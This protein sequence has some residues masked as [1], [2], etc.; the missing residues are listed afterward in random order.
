MFL[1]FLLS[2][3]TDKNT[4]TGGVIDN[5]CKTKE[6]R[7]REILDLKLREIEALERLAKLKEDKQR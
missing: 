1:E 4:F 6:S 2:P 5:Y 7:R 3:I